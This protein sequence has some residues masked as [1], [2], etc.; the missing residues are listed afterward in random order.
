MSLSD[1]TYKISSA[2][3]KTDAGKPLFVGLSGK[4]I[5]ATA[6]GGDAVELKKVTDGLYTLKFSRSGTFIGQSGN[7]LQFG[8]KAYQWR[9]MEV[10]SNEYKIISTAEDPCW[11]LPQGAGNP[12]QI[13]L[14]RPE[15]LAGQFWKFN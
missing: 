1:G 13:V 11:T 5:V 7:Q 15:G 4:N 6:S 8:P 12:S 10:G 14:F 3:V 2:R 9:V